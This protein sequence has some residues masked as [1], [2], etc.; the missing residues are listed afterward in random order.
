M[1]CLQ[2]TQGPFLPSSPP[3]GPSFPL[4]H[5][6]IMGSYS[7]SE[8]PHFT[9]IHLHSGLVWTAEGPAEAA[10]G[11]R[12]KKEQWVGVEP[13]LSPLTHPIRATERWVKMCPGPHGP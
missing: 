10:P 7:V 1:F 3:H 4:P 8:S 6:G 9:P 2:G 12:K 13:C 5:T 11:Q